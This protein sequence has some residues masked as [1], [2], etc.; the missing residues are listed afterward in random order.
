MTPGVSIFSSV[1][2]ATWAVVNGTP[3][4]DYPAQNLADLIRPSK[5]MRITPSSGSCGVTF[6]FNTFTEQIQFIAL[7][8]HNASVGNWRVI[9][10]SDNNPDPVGNV[11]NIILNTGLVPIWPTG[12]ARVTGYTPTTPLLLANPIN[13]GSGRIDFS[14]LSGTLEIGAVELSQFLEWDISPGVEFGLSTDMQEQPVVGGGSDVT[15][16]LLPRIANG[17]I[18][19]V[20]L[21][22]SSSFFID[23]QQVSGK[24]QPFVFVQDYDDVTTWGRWCFLA[25]NADLPPMV[26]ALYRSDKFQFRLKEHTR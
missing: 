7:V 6:N 2:V 19:F 14:A 16:T 15:D 1:S 22:N 8:R 10:W 25:R 11:G 12:S 21:A 9:L 20:P 17:Q 18:D 3:N 5:V 23:F 13:V 4:A 24:A 26:G